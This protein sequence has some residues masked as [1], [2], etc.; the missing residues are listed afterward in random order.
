[1]YP[2]TLENIGKIRVQEFKKIIL[3]EEVTSLKGETLATPNNGIRDPKGSSGGLR[4]PWEVFLVT[5]HSSLLQ[6]GMKC[7]QGVISKLDQKRS[8]H[9]CNK[10][11][12]FKGQ[13]QAPP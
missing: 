12:S 10:G 13:S 9:V 6:E 3:V 11:L 2:S 5:P 7:H 1:M 4:R 8:S